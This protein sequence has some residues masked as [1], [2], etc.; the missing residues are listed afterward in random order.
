MPKK[1]N[2]SNNPMEELINLSMDELLTHKKNYEE[3][4]NEV[5]AL[6]G[7]GPYDFDT[8]QGIM[9]PMLKIK[10]AIVKIAIDAKN[11]KGNDFGGKVDEI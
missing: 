1:H 9:V 11:K 4:L 8:I 5:T 7:E 10:L 6:Y 2:D 3:M